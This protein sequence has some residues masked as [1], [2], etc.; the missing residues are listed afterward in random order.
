MDLKSE[1]D[2]NQYLKPVLDQ[3]SFAASG[4][5]AARSGNVS[6]VNALKDAVNMMLDTSAQAKPEEI[7]TTV[8]E[9]VTNSK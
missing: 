4:K 6:A 8:K 1:L 9:K 5:V 7:M 3:A 2:T